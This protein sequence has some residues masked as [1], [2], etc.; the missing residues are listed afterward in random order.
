MRKALGGIAISCAMLL[1]LSVSST[2]RAAADGAPAAPSARSPEAAATW[3]GR[4][5]EFTFIPAIGVFEN[6][7]GSVRGVN[8]QD[9]CVAAYI[10]VGSGWWTKPG[11]GHPCAD[12]SETGAW[13]VDITTA[14]QDESAV[15]VAAFLWPR[16]SG[17]PPRAAGETALHE[18]LQQVSHAGVKAA[19]TLKGNRETAFDFVPPLGSLKDLRGTSQGVVFDNYCTASYIRVGSLWWTKPTF[20]APCA[21]ISTDGTW[22]VDITT[23]GSDATAVEILSFLWPKGAGQPPAAAG[24]ASLAQRLYRTSP[25]YVHSTRGDHPRK[26]I[27]SGLVWEVKSAAAQTGPGPNYFSDSVDNV[28]VNQRTGD[29]HLKITNRDGKWRCAEVF[30]Q[31]SFG[32]G[33]Y[34]FVRGSR[35]NLLDE[36]VVLGLFIW[37]DS[38]AYNHREIDIEF[39]RWGEEQNLNSQFVVQPW[40]RP[41][42]MFRFE[43][44]EDDPLG[45]RFVWKEGTVAFSGSSMTFKVTGPD[46]PP[47]GDEK[48]RLNLWLYGG[49]PPSDGQE[50]EAVIKRFKHDLPRA[51]DGLGAVSR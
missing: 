29:I 4:A 20:D 47:P 22:T 36:N 15:N 7:R 3:P 44:A 23:G 16:A 27:F 19:R 11:V 38:S 33:R 42:N 12:I 43:T 48:V 46:V 37:D 25:A 39:S 35:V 6:L 28:W 45:Y 26:L 24:A 31:R 41:A 34:T 50:A 51:E 21:P 30:T 5:I 8:F 14:E 32:Y 13:K 49:T 18:G 2:V 1:V 40:S 9:Y 10:Q 17:P